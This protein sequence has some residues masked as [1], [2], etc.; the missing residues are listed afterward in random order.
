MNVSSGMY[1]FFSLAL[2]SWHIATFVLGVFLSD[3]FDVSDT[4]FDLKSDIKKAMVCSFIALTPTLFIYYHA[5][6]GRIIFV[7]LLLIVF[8]SKLAYLGTNHGAL[9]IILGTNLV[10]LLMFPMIF[11][12]L[13]L[14][15][16]ITLALAALIV[17]LVKYSHQ[18]KLEKLQIRKNKHNEQKIRNMARM[19]SDF[20]TLCLECKHYNQDKNDCQRKIDLQRVK[21]L[22]INGK[23]YCAS[24]ENINS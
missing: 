20:H 8:S 14:W 19:H 4:G 18:K 2:Y 22:H 16:I 12:I 24:W 11:K 1:L 10:G 13:R 7:Y 21:D 5:P 15:G 3:H 23:I 9:A 6:D 17:L